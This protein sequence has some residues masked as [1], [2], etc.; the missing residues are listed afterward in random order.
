MHWKY[1]NIYIGGKFL[2]S[3]NQIGLFRQHLYLQSTRGKSNHQ[4]VNK[5]LSPDSGRLANRKLSGA[6]IRG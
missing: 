1:V 2:N 4:D 3:A 6:I 5:L